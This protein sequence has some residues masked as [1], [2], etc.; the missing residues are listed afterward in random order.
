MGWYSDAKNAVIEAAKKAAAAVAAAL[1]SAKKRAEDLA[2]AAVEAAKKAADQAKAIAAAA[3][4]KAKAA[5]AAAKA[6]AKKAAEAAAAKASAALKKAQEKAAKE[7]AAAKKKAEEALKKVTDTVVS[8]ATPVLAPLADEWNIFTAVMMNIFV[9][10]YTVQGAL[11]KEKIVPAWIPKIIDSV[12]DLFSINIAPEGETPVRVMGLGGSTIIKNIPKVSAAAANM[13]ITQM[14]DGGAEKVIARAT[15]NPKGLAMK[16]FSLSETKLAKVFES[17]GSTKSGRIALVRVTRV[18]EEWGGKEIIEK[19][20]LTALLAKAKPRTITWGIAGILGLMSSAYGIS[21]GTEWFAKE[22]LVELVQIP[23][24]SKMRD[25]RFE[26]TP[27]KAE[28]IKKDIAKLEEVV[29]KAQALIKSVSW[30]WPFTKDDWN[31]YS[32][33]LTFEQQQIK[34]EFNAINEA[35]EKKA[36]K[37][38]PEKV[39]AVVRDIIDGD[40]I[41]VGLNAKDANTGESFEM[42]EYS[43][44]GHARIRLVGINTPEKSPKGEILCS[45]VEIYK[46]EGKWADEARNRL[47]PLNDK[48]VILKIDLSQPTDTHGRLLAVVEYQGTDINVRQLKEGLACGYYREPHKWVNQA[49]NIAETLEALKNHRGMWGDIVPVTGAEP[50][51]EDVEGVRTEKVVVEKFKINVTT[52]PDR[53]KLYIDGTYTHHLTPSNETELSDVMDLLVPGKHI[54]SV[55]KKDLYGE[56]AVDVVGGDNG[57]ITIPLEATPGQVLKVEEPPVIP[58]VVPEVVPEV[59]ELGPVDPTEI[60]TEYT[61]E[62]EWALNELFGL[63]FTLIEGAAQMSAE[64]FEELKAHFMLYTAPQR[65]VVDLALRDIWEH[66]KGAAQLSEEEFL[67]LKTKYR[68]M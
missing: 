20:G 1:A 3:L 49:L 64:E 16:L 21:F 58:E 65:L 42:P 27:E 12:V 22:G 56:V 23:L 62:Q 4:A 46:V 28:L 25:Y 11:A 41:D 30:L 68:L 59:E 26:A 32:D 43:T 5:E 10:G 34:T 15:A 39:E 29:P 53:A 50:V 44:S 35:E 67:D 8:I 55:E 48:D 19:K 51:I 2:K 60:P 7:A 36:G 6:A 61:T 57:V 40:T 33:S 14:I 66:T 47:M 24:S 52:A 17:L 63:T 38:M 37:G 54:F 9:E 18:M 31:T 45:D 13:L